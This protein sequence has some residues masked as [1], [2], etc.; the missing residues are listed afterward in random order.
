M[1]ESEAIRAEVEPAFG[2]RVTSLVD[3]RTGRDWLVPGA[4]VPGGAYGAAQAVGWDE[5]FPP[6]R[7]AS[8]PT[9]V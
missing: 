2:A 7:R 5:C 1:V 8:T 3:R 6:W 9:G 4:A